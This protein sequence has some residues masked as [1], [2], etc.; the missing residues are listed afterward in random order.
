MAPTFSTRVPK[1]LAKKH[2]SIVP[3]TFSHSPERGNISPKHLLNKTKYE[4]KN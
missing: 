2:E 4:I 3:V 1:F